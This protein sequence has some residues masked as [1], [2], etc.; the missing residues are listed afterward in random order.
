MH[1]LCLGPPHATN[2]TCTTCCVLAP[3]SA[4]TV[5]ILIL[6]GTWELFSFSRCTTLPARQLVGGISLAAVPLSCTVH[7]AKQF[8]YKDYTS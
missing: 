2:L 8:C 7:D 3:S 6:T 4:V 1:A 5:W